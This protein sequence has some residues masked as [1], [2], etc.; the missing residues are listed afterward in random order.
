M[1]I[2]TGSNL[3]EN[4]FVKAPSH[5][6]NSVF[7]RLF[8]WY[9][10]YKFVNKYTRKNKNEKYEFI[11]ATSNPPINSYLGLKLK[12]RFNT[13]FVFMN[14]DLYPQVIESS[15][16]GIIPK[17]ISKFW[18][19]KNSRIYPKIDRM[20]TIGEV[21][22]QTINASLEKK[23]PIDIIPM[24]TDTQQLQP[25]PKSKNEFCIKNNLVDKFI[26]LYSGKMGL[27]HNLK[28]LLNA[29][30][31]LS[32]YNDI[33][34][35]FIGYGQQYNFIE[36][37]ISENKVKNIRI[38]PLQSE[39]DFPKS[40]ASGDIGFVSQE[41]AA[42]K[43]FMPA[44]TYDMMS[45]GLAILAYSEGNDDLS[46]LVKS[47]QIGKTLSQNDPEHL[48]KLIK[49]L[50]LNK[51]LLNLYKENARKTAIELFDIEP[52]TSKYRKAFKNVEKYK[53][54]GDRDD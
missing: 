41:K 6:A 8:S 37:W 48:S 53:E 38:M 50:Y 14:W 51:N 43:F 16:K 33:L 22:G 10:F 1:D 45:C 28:I 49:E 3:Q 15:M 25:I 20:I 47:H 52:V 39:K 54:K 9:A 46:N 31:Y 23:I 13:N 5:K 29:S 26:V 19:Y 44:K 2:I 36:K 17:I 34:F 21:M 24:F 4:G 40:M 12:K 32:G 11:F 27:G 18:H 42:S 30:T 7:S 35:L